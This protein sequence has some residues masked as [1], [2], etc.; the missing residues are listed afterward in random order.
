MDYIQGQVKRLQWT[1]RLDQGFQMIHGRLCLL[2]LLLFFLL[3]FS[4]FL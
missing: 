1:G 2:Y 3:L 4:L